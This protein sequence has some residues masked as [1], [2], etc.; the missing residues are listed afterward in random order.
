MLSSP[1]SNYRA[2]QIPSTSPRILFAFFGIHLPKIF[3]QLLN[4]EMGTIADKFMT[5]KIQHHLFPVPGLYTDTTIIWHSS[6]NTGSEGTYK[7]LKKVLKI[8]ALWHTPDNAQDGRVNSLTIAFRQFRW[9]VAMGSV[10]RCLEW[11]SDLRIPQSL[12]LKSLILTWGF[13]KSAVA[14]TSSSTSTVCVRGWFLH[15]AA[16]WPSRPWVFIHGSGREENT[17]HMGTPAQDEYL[18]IQRDALTSV[19]LAFLEQY[20]ASQVLSLIKFILS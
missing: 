14:S 13:H 2:L 9:L 11:P 3:T 19:Y 17:A 4:W 15:E 5:S 7:L 6:A 16:E 1:H 20:R 18:Q 8:K 12:C 10:L